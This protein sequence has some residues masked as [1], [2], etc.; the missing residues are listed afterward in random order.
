MAL[1][2]ESWYL[3]SSLALLSSL[4]LR[5]LFAPSFLSRYQLLS[6]LPSLLTGE[7]FPWSPLDSPHRLLH[8]I[9]SLVSLCSIGLMS[10]SVSVM[11]GAGHSFFGV[12]VKYCFAR[13][14]IMR[15][16]IPTPDI[17]ITS[18]L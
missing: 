9:F 13:T 10:N 14:P 17:I 3:E 15:R 2:V 11:F 18:I 5:D 4:S 8:G 1:A 16:P 12:L 7:M 6:I